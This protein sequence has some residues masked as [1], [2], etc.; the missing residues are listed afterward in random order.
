RRVALVTYVTEADRSSPTAPFPVERNRLEVVELDG[1]RLRTLVDRIEPGDDTTAAVTWSP[2]GRHIAFRSGLGVT[3]ALP[4][5]M[6][7]PQS[8]AR[9]P[10]GTDLYVAD[11]TSGD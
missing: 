11:V 6:T 4:R 1:K 10:A 9:E 5:V 7:R 2:D 3:R 8:D